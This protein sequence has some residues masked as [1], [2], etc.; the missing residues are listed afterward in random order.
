MNTFTPVPY[1]PRCTWVSLDDVWD[2][3][4][5]RE[6][7]VDQAEHFELLGDLDGPLADSLVDRNRQ[8]LR[9]DAAGRVSCR[10]GG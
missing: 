2:V 4:L 9:G 10:G 8:R 1:V 5:Y 7:D 6:L 3:V